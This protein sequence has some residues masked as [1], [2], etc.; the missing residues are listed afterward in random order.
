M[1]KADLYKF[2]GLIVFFVLVVVG[3]AL[4]WPYVHSLF[5]EGGL[6]L[7]ISEVRKAG[8]IGVL[9][10][11]A[12]QFLQI[13]VAFI[14]G[15]ITQVA[16]GMLYGP[17]LGAAIILVGCAISSAFVYVIVNKLGAPFVRAM[18][19]AKYLEKFDRLERTGNALSQSVFILF[20]IPGLQ[21]TCSPTSCR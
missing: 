14:P 7:V 16:A 2:V 6:D 9:M 10:L 11:L 13:V 4:L 5:E 15:E 8:P 12:M 20:L 3:I 1:T 18:V 21:R 19:P 17:W